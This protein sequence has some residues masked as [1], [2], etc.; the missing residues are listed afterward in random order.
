MAFVVFERLRGFLCAQGARPQCIARPRRVRMAM[1][2]IEKTWTRF[3]GNPIAQ[4]TLI[5]LLP[6]WLGSEKLGLATQVFRRA[7]VSSRHLA[8]PP[9]EMVIPGRTFAQ[10]NEQYKRIIRE[11]IGELSATIRADLSKEERASV[12]LLVTASCT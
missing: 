6:A 5:G 4:E 9:A 11:E 2:I 7:A 3:P 8:V 10:K 1:T 12:A